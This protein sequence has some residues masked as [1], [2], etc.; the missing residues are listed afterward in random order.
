MATNLLL[1][2]L[3][4]HKKYFNKFKVHSRAVFSILL[5]AAGLFIPKAELKAQ[6]CTGGTVIITIDMRGKPDTIW[7]S[8]PTVRENGT[9]CGNNARCIDF[10]IIPDTNVGA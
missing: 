2:Y 3:A 1:R 4:E 10:H 7:T 8:S 9:C 5:L 6:V